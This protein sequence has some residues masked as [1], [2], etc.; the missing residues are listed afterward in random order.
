MYSI[1][2]SR[3]AAKALRA[4]PRNVAQTIV[5]KIEQLA[6]DPCALNNNVLRLKGEADYR[7]RVGD[8][9]VIYSLDG[10]R[11]VVE[12]L[13]IRPRGGAYQ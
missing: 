5:G 11:L 9:R 6:L 4:M 13:R 10:K 12:V 3:E 8:W 7:M 1:E 2:Y